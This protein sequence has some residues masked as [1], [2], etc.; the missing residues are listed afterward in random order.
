MVARNLYLAGKAINEESVCAEVDTIS[1][2]RELYSGIKLFE[3]R[4]VLIA[5]HSEL[6]RDVLLP[7]INPQDLDNYYTESEKKSGD[8]NRFGK[9]ALSAAIR[10]QQNDGNLLCEQIR[11]D[12]T[13]QSLKNSKMAILARIRTL[14]PPATFI[15]DGHGLKDAWYLFDG[16]VRPNNL[17]NDIAIEFAEVSIS[18]EE[19]SEAFKERAKNF[20][21]LKESVPEGTAPVGKDIVILNSCFS[22]N[23]ARSLFDSLGSEPKPII[24]AA[25]EYSQLS[26]SELESPFGSILFHRLLDPTRDEPT[27]FRH[28]FEHEWRSLSEP[29]LY[30]PD[31]DNQPRQISQSP[32]K[33]SR[34]AVLVDTFRKVLG[35]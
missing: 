22:S 5:A 16:Q 10:E 20:P 30:I 34:I 29:A 13:E 24:L 7:T 21:Q 31:E 17:D 18:T 1:K 4:N 32:Q 8:V 23:L 26:Y 6:I 27:S 14:P 11:P 9:N 12:K 35:V 2:N 3:G 28:F 19:L 15:F 25:S 33:P